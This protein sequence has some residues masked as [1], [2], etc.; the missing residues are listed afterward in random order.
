M[1]QSANLAGT[2]S[3]T[4]SGTSV[5]GVGTAFGTDFA[6]GDIITTSGG[7]SRRI[8]VIGGTT[9]M[10]VTPAWSS[11]ES[12]HTYKRGGKAPNTIY[13]LHAIYKDSD[14]SV[15]YAASPRDTP[16]DLPTGYSKFRQIWHALTDASS[17]NRPY[18]QDG[19]RCDLSAP[20]TELSASYFGGSASSVSIASAAPPLVL[21]EH[22]VNGVASSAQVAT[23]LYVRPASRTAST[24]RPVVTGVVASAKVG[25]RVTTRLD[26][27][28]QFAIDYNVPNGDQLDV[29][30]YLLGWTFKRGRR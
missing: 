8:T 5:T 22:D 28:S 16:S 9:S 19:D 26:G 3:V 29:L 14:G 15:D 1:L 17:N 4:A 21:A 23:A 12:T 10:T 11:T 20:I 13:R 30:I 2:I 24:G 7:Q 27:S 18:V 25:G 6:V